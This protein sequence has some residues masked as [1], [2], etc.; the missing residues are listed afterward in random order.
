MNEAALK[1][2]IHTSRLFTLL[3]SSVLQQ[4]ALMAEKDFDHKEKPKEE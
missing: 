4:E 1:A 2:L 3:L